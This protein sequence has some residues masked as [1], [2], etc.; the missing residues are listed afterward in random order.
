MHK[1][2]FNHKL[3]DSIE[4]IG[5]NSNEIDTIVE[6]CITSINNLQTKNNK[7][8]RKSEIVEIILN[9]GLCVREICI[10]SFHLGEMYNS[11][12]VP[13]NPLDFSNCCSVL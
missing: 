13:P 2:I 7:F 11:V 3:E 1:T 5:L 6:S 8:V 9:K 4:A 10:I 12:K